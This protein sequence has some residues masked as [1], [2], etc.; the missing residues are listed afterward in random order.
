MCLKSSLIN[1]PPFNC[2]QN[3]TIKK[4]KEANIIAVRDDAINCYKNDGIRKKIG[5]E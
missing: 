5:N 2:P 3:M 4:K 1:D